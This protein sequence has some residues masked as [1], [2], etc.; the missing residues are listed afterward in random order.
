MFARTTK[1]RQSSMAPRPS[2]G[3]GSDPSASRIAKEPHVKK[4]KV[5]P[6]SFRCSAERIST[7]P[8]EIKEELRS[9]DASNIYGKFDSVSGYGFVILNQMVCVWDC[10]SLASNKFQIPHTDKE[11]FTDLVT[12][13][14]KD[15]KIGLAVCTQEGT[16]RTWQSV[17]DAGTYT[18]NSLRTNAEPSYIAFCEPFGVVVGMQGGVDP[19]LYIVPQD[20]RPSRSFKIGSSW[21]GY[22]LGT[23]KYPTVVSIIPGPRRTN[24][25]EL[26]VLTE[27]TLQKWDLYNNT[28]KMQQELTVH[29]RLKDELFQ[30]DRSEYIITL[31]DAKFVNEGHIYVLASCYLSHCPTDADRT[32]SYHVANVR[33]AGYAMEIINTFEVNLSRPHI[34]D[35]SEYDSMKSRLAIPNSTTPNSTTAFVCFSDSIVLIQGYDKE[36]ISFAGDR[37]VATGSVKKNAYIVTEKQGCLKLNVL[38]DEYQGEAPSQTQAFAQLQPPT[39]KRDLLAFA[40]KA[41]S[42]GDKRAAAHHGSQIGNELSEMA[43]QMSLSILDTPPS[44]ASDPQWTDTANT[45]FLRKQIDAKKQRHAMLMDLLKDQEFGASLWQ[46]LSESAQLD[47]SEN[48]DKLAAALQLRTTQASLS[49]GDVNRE[50]LIQRA[51]KRTL[52]E[53]KVEHVRSAI[54]AQEMYYSQVSTVDEILGPVYEFLLAVR[55]ATSHINLEVSLSE[56]RDANLIYQAFFSSLSPAVLARQRTHFG[57]KPL[58][59]RSLGQK[60]LLLAKEFLRT[61]IGPQERELFQ[62]IYSITHSVLAS[63]NFEVTFLAQDALR[64]TYYETREELL[65]SFLPGHQEM[66]IQLAEEFLDFHILLL[67]CTENQDMERVYEYMRRFS[68]DGFP[69]FVFHNFYVNKRYHE[70]MTL[71]DDFNEQLMRFL[72]P[73]PD[74]AWLQFLHCQ[75]YGEAST[76]LKTANEEEKESLGRKKVLLSLAKLSNLAH[77]VRATPDKRLEQQMYMLRLQKTILPTFTQPL[78]PHDLVMKIMYKSHAPVLQN[79]MSA[80]DAAKNSDTLVSEEQKDRLLEEIWSFAL[81]HGFSWNQVVGDWKS[82]RMEDAALRQAIEGSVI[83][84]AAAHPNNTALLSRETVS[85]VF[86]AMLKRFEETAPQDAQLYARI[87]ETIHNVVL[88]LPAC[89]GN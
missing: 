48:G 14:K 40:L 22:L 11:I 15:N 21:F 71:P 13:T 8:K 67:I 20:N 5:V 80:L 61:D 27:Y 64:A 58:T 59:L 17:E 84:N 72:R 79:V 45:M 50:S 77:D 68:K 26:Y 82:G 63:F 16:L 57:T 73:Y 81:Q 85:A 55:P 43:T 52:D 24:L 3:P 75:K 49:E 47:I 28:E 86:S 23:T 10:A 78:E 31:L 7:F 54:T 25:T 6:L 89:E 38:E 62:Q 2:L 37:I 46:R 35:A 29:A 87:L 12:L 34:F 42:V 9:S 4:D 19:N 88:S 33:L 51:I 1:R 76:A 30:V 60:Y 32:I 65:K 74:L 70:L 18:D 36:E 69:D 39:N 44:T 56:F 53:R 83:Y 66:A 41:Y